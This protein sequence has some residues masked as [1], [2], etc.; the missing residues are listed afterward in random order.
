MVGIGQRQRDEAI[1]RANERVDGHRVRTLAIDADVTQASSFASEATSDETYT[2]EALTEESNRTTQT[3]GAS[4]GEPAV[5]HRASVK[6]SSEHSKRSPPSQR[7]L[8]N[9]GDSDY[10]LSQQ[11]ELHPSEPSGLSQQRGIQVLGEE[12]DSQSSRGDL[13][14][15]S[16]D[17]SLRVDKSAS[18]KKNA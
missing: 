14:Q 15:I 4:S 16:S 5:D 12:A 13:P 11:S 6:R 9:A 7:K 8:R 1:R 3:S 2:I 17:T 10:D 18:N